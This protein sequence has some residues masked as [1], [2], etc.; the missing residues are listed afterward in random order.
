MSFQ[1][2][3]FISYRR[4]D[5]RDKFI[6]EFCK[7]INQYAFDATDKKDYFLDRKEIEGSP[8]YGKEIYEAI[9]TSYFF[10]VFHNYHYLSKNNL[11]CAKELKYA[12]A[13]EEARKK[14][15]KESDQDDFCFFNVFIINGKK[16]DLPNYIK[17]RNAIEIAAFQYSKYDTTAWQDFA[18]RIGNFMLDVYRIY[19][20]NPNDFNTCCEHI[21]EPTDDEI[22]EWINEQKGIMKNNESNHLP[23]L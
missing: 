13:V 4:E 15:L 11:W 2:S 22:R 21:T 16:S 23:K 20:R 12:I 18:Q 6:D 17:D 7:Q 1:Y 5:V 3:C 8:K 19:E 9:R 14:I 10:N